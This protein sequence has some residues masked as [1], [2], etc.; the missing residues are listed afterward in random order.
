[1]NLSSTIASGFFAT[2]PSI[3]LTYTRATASVT[4]TS[5]ERREE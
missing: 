3:I 1:L 2:F 4:I 5:N